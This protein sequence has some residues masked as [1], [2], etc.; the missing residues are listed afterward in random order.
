MTVIFM[1]VLNMSITAALAACIILLFRGV[2]GS[3][4]P[5]QFSYALWGIVLVRLTLPFSFSSPFSILDKVNPNVGEYGAALSRSYSVSGTEGLQEAPP[6]ALAEA[7]DAETAA[8]Y[9]AHIAEGIQPGISFMELCAFIWVA[10]I[11]AMLLYSVISYV[12][13]GRR[14]S[15]AVR[16]QNETMAEECRADIKLKRPCEIYVSDQIEGPFVYGVVRSRILLP[17][18]LVKE[19]CCEEK[20]RHILLHE[21]VHIKRFDFILKPL[22]FLAVIVHWFNPVIWICFFL[23]NKD[24]EMSCDEQVVRS[25]P[26]CRN[27]SYANTLLELSMR[28]NRLPETSFLAFG[29]SSISARVKNI[30]KYERPKRWMAAAAVLLLAVCGVLLL[31]DPQGI[32]LQDEK[33]SLLL[34][35][36]RAAEAEENVPVDTFMLVS[37]EPQ[38]GAVN[39]ISIPRDIMVQTEERELR[40]SQYAGLY[41]PKQVLEE[42]NRQLGTQ[43]SHYIRLDTEAFGALVDA[44]GGIEFDVPFAM[45]YDDI[46]DTPPLHIDLEKGMQRLDGKKAEMLVRFRGGH[47][48]GQQ[49]RMA[50]QQDLLE[51]LLIQGGKSNLFKNADSI[52]DL[53]SE[54]ITTNI[55]IKQLKTYLSVLEKA[56]VQAE[57]ISQLSLPV[58]TDM[59]NGIYSVEIQ[60]EEASQLLES[61]F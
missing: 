36:V 40:L 10:G 41:P 53:L 26:V 61:R 16:F 45:K 42:I 52:Y 50:V 2:A 27:G 11:A 48:Q 5:R 46:Y 31:S 7:V 15:A 19:E 9:T 13:M 17:A 32:R 18:F 21:M 59:K 4:L 23:A 35:G 39:M 12:R 24:M 55:G 58:R 38:S 49:S 43:V 25:S 28:Q 44:V 60:K 56:S 54:D 22:T 51:A 37:Y 6:Q 1:T 3:R 29:E 34:M 30:L 47:P 8:G 33:I 20:L 14:I 57:D